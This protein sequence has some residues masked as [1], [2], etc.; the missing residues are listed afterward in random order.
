MK[1]RSLI[2]LAAVLIIPTASTVVRL[3]SASAQRS[4]DRGQ[5]EIVAQ[6]SQGQRPQL[7]P[8]QREA[9]RAEREA[10]FKETLALSDEQAQNIKEIRESYRPQMQSFREE[11]R[12]LREQG[13]DSTELESI[14]AQKKELRTKMYEEIKAELTPEQVQ[15]L[16]ELKAQKGK[17]RGSKE[18]HNRAR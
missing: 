4:S 5:S 9:K 10:K 12:A 18:A 8:E 3:S 1:N 13:A 11:A 17:R 7:S 16:E 14:L 6:R 2:L 15:K